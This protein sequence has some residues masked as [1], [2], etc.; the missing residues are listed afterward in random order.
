M[1]VTTVHDIQRILLD[2]HDILNYLLTVI[3]IVPFAVKNL[4]TIKIHTCKT[5]TIIIFAPGVEEYKTIKIS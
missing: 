2:G 3:M 5:I 4:I 1:L